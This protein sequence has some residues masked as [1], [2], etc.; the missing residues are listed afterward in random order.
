MNSVGHHQQD[1]TQGLNARL[2]CLM[3]RGEEHQD[4]STESKLKSLCPG[5]HNLLFAKWVPTSTYF[6]RSVD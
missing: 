2:L 5:F 6:R 3:N 4:L 1:L